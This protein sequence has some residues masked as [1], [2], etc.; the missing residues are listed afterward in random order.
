MT[1]ESCARTGLVARPTEYGPHRK[2]DLEAE[3]D[4]DSVAKDFSRDGRSTVM[5][6]Q[7]D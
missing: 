1:I 4:W 5:F 6:R 3:G 7:L 2:Y